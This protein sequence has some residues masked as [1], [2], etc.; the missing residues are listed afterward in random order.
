MNDNDLLARLADAL[1]LN[2]DTCTR[3]NAEHL[4]DVLLSLPGIAIVDR[5]DFD[6]LLAVAQMY[7]DAF[8][9]DELMSLTERMRL[10]MIEDILAAANAAER[11]DHE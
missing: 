9:E 3:A 1:R 5:A 11:N 2:G 7:V 10:Q 4:A 6:Q 8:R